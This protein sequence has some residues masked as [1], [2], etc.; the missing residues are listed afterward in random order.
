MA[1]REFKGIEAV[2]IDGYKEVPKLTKEIKHKISAATRPLNRAKLIDAI[3]SAF[4]EIGEEIKPILTERFPDIELARLAA[5]IVNGETGLKL[6]DDGV[7]EQLNEAVKNSIS[8][9]E[10]DDE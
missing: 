8:V 7:R 5:Y 6:V 1:L 4:P 10:A 9:G 3:V 2:K